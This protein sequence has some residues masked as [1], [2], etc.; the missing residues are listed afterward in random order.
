MIERKEALLRIKELF[1]IHSAVG[2]VGPRQC[3]KTTLARYIEK[4]EN[5]CTFF[6]LESAIDRRKLESPELSLKNLDGTVI[7]DEIQR[8]PQLFET[9]RV[10]LDRSNNQTQFLLPGSA[11]PNL[12]KGVSESLAGRVGI[13][14]LGGFDLLEIGAENWQTLWMR[15]GYPRAFLGKDD[16]SAALWRENFVRTF[17]ERD[18]P[19]LGISIPAETLRRFWTMIAHYHGQVWNASEFA[20]ALGANEHTARRYLDILAGAYVVRVLPPWFENIKKR[21]VKS[22]KIYVR[23]SGL[24]HSLLGIDTLSDLSG[25]PKIGA[26]WEGF[27]IEQLISCLNKQS[28]YFWGTHAGAELDI[29]TTVR[30]KRYGFECKYSDAPGSSKSMRA[31]INDLQLNHLWVVYPGE[32]KYDIDKEISILPLKQIPKLIEKLKI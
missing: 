17:L 29:L 15:G 3:G 24:L 25:H 19:Q 32:S 31:A 5:E 12:I 7:I 1:R 21:Q 9:L 2:L 11:S 28:T 18:I 8:M 4:E 30:G 22:P 10:L 27:V 14:D 6:D 26:S 20:R 16:Q 13:V 23:D